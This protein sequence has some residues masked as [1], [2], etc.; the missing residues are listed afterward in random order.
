MIISLDSNI[1]TQPPNISNQSHQHPTPAFTMSVQPSPLLQ[2][3]LLGDDIR[4]FNRITMASMTRNRNT[5]NMKPTHLTST[6]YT[7][8]ATA[9]LIISEG[10]HICPQATQWEH[11][12][13]MYLPE[14]AEAWKSVTRAVHA[15]GGKIFMQIWHAGRAQNENMSWAKDNAAFPGVWAPSNVKAAGG[16]FR[17]GDGEYLENTETLTAIEDSRSVVE[18]FKKSAVLSKQAGFDGVE[19]IALGGY[20]VHSFMN[21][22]AN[23]RTDE[24][25][26]SVLNRCRFPLEVVDAMIDVYGQRRVGV[27]I[28]P[29]DCYNDSAATCA[30][31]METFTYLI[32]QLVQ[33]EIAYICLSRRAVE[34][35]LGRR[36]E[37]FLL[38]PGTDPV[39]I[40][41]P[42]V[43]NSD[44]KTLFMVNEGYTPSEAEELM[45]A[46][47]IDLIA[48]GR[49]YIPN[50]DLV[51]RIEKALPLAENDR[52][53]HVHYGPFRCPEEDYTD[54]PRAV[55][56]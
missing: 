15:A 13:V 2:P 40:F 7:Q 22:R 35:F 14:H 10:I 52:G 8:R 25:G 37:G 55:S 29:F 19:V 5:N 50:P 27:K 51:A 21:S 32:D 23:L 39:S 41:G 18:Q 56:P 16:R 30:E 31:C 45:E 46:G 38:P 28:S 43:K 20:L 53:S 9:G 49:L 26:G 54:W 12:P 36:P 48:F 3:I 6:Y 47:K 42:M 4:L 11:V 24:Y 1:N 17:T 44:S 33:R 34:P